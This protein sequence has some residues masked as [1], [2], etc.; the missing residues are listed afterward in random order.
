M[1]SAA[2]NTAG[3]TNIRDSTYRFHADTCGGFEPW[4][5]VL[6]ARLSFLARAVVAGAGQAWH[7]EFDRV[8]AFVASGGKEA[9]NNAG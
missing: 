6:A 3:T 4:I 7:V 2:A 9:T 1:F 8:A 5:S